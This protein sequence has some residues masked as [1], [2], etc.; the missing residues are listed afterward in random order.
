MRKCID[1]AA[2]IRELRRLF[3]TWGLPRIVVSDNGPSL[4]SDEITNFYK[5]NGIKH[6]PIPSYKPQ[7]NGLAERMVGTFKSS[8]KKMKDKCSNVSKN[9]ACWLLTY[10]NT[11]HGTSKQTPAEV[12]LGRRTRSRL[13]LLYPEVSPNLLL[14]AKTQVERDF[15]LGEQIYYKD[16]RHDT[17]KPGKVVER[18]GEKI[19]LVQGQ[20]GGTHMK[21]IDQLITGLPNSG[22]ERVVNKSGDRVLVDKS[23]NRP[24]DRVVTDDNKHVPE[25]DLQPNISTSTELPSSTGSPSNVSSELANIDSPSSA[26][27]SPLVSHRS[28]G[29]EVKQPD[30]LTYFE[31]GGD[32]KR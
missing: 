16:T 13:S 6:V 24:L 7:C 12:M 28:S 21:H 17:W 30:R 1:S 31:L 14:S 32:R 10:R 2:T 3:A 4:V 25:P 5:S 22:V 26:R 18:Q 29:R 11:P 20:E 23:L 19:Y 8:M 15:K 9:L 27:V